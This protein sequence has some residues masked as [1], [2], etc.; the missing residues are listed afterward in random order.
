M[1]KKAPRSVRL[2]SYAV[3]VLAYHYRVATQ[4]NTLFT[5]ACLF[6][7]LKNLR[8]AASGPSNGGKGLIPLSSNLL[9][10]I[11]SK[12]SGLHTRLPFDSRGLLS[13]IFADYLALAIIW[14]GSS[15]LA[16]LHEFLLLSRLE[17]FNKVA[18]YGYSVAKQLADAGV[19]VIEEAL[20]AESDKMETKLEASIKKPLAGR[21]KNIALPAQGVNGKALIK[22]LRAWGKEEDE[23]WKAGKVSGAVYLNDH[24][25]LDVLMEATTAFGISNPLHPDIWPSVMKFESEIVSMV[26]RMMD[27]GP[28]N[29]PR[30][31][32]VC[33]VLTSGGTESITMSVKTHRDW[34]KSERGVNVPELIIC[35]TA[36]AAFDKACDILGVK[37]VKV[38]ADPVTFQA[39]VQAMA[40]RITA[41]TIMIV[42]SAPSFPQGVIDDIPALA[43]VAKSHGIGLHVDCCLGGFILPF[44]KQLK[45]ADGVTPLYP[46]IPA[47]DFGVQG[48][49]AMSVDTHKYGY[50]T[51]GTSVVLYNNK[52]LRK[53]QYFMYPDW[54]GGLYCTPTIA[55]SRSGAVSAACWASL[56][57]MGHD[58]Y[59]TATRK[60]M[61]VKCRIKEGIDKIPGI[62]VFGDPQAMVVAFG[63]DYFTAPDGSKKK[64]NIYTLNDILKKKHYNLNSLNHPP[65]LHICCT[66]PHTQNG[67]VEQFL[68]DVREASEIVMAN[69]DMQDDDGMAPVYGTAEKLPGNAVGDFLA[70]YMDIIL[71]V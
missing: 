1:V 10:W 21:P 47:F 57:H 45:K 63:S 56:M 9:H 70:T 39:D 35:A 66:L 5:A 18:G 55:G 29:E 40:S 53:F 14:K 62:K 67:F 64:F 28:E 27:G 19:P 31:S 20:Q 59:M 26:A 58:G 37:C 22:K 50:T 4:G 30:A 44:A 6:V 11:N 41:N 25:H 17:Q 33:G 48:V 43:K 54:T 49:T 61:D 7:L 46:D 52:Q 2:F 16:N 36:H 42:G 60:I 51:K 24:Q 13:T 15:M 69:P 32:E 65:C 38:P 8:L 3:S 12:V 71:K 34:A 23:G 68:S